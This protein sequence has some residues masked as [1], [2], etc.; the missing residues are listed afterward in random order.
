MTTTTATATAT[1][2]TAMAIDGWLARLRILLKVGRVR[3]AAELFLHGL[4]E[5]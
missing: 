2:I 5:H 4:R 3:E 1:T